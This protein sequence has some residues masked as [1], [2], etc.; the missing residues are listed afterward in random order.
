MP[1]KILEVNDFQH[2][3]RSRNSRYARGR[4][5]DGVTEEKCV[6]GDVRNIADNAHHRS[7]YYREIDCQ[8]GD[9]CKPN[10]FATLQEKGEKRNY[11]WDY[12]KVL[13]LKI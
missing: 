1:D 7:S 5:Q 2:Y 9:G 8:A 13:M 10:S 12:V 3:Q 6:T 11:D 4:T